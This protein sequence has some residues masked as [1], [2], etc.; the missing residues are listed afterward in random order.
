MPTEGEKPPTSPTSEKPQGRRN[1][2]TS[3]FKAQ[4]EKLPQSAQKAAHEAFKLF[5]SSPT[6][7]ALQSHPLKDTHKGRHKKGSIS[8]TVT[9]R[10]RAIYVVDGDTNVWY[11]IGTHEDYNSFTGR[12]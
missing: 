6:H 3:N 8:V 4:F 11:W 9:Y 1:R 2:R 10:Y 5:C 12:M 7:P